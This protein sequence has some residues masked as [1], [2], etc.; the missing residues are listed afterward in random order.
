MKKLF[1]RLFAFLVALTLLVGAAATEGTTDPETQE[2]PDF[3]GAFY[4]PEGYYNSAG[5]YVAAGY[6]FP[7]GT[8]ISKE[9]A[10]MAK[11]KGFALVSLGK[12][13]L[14]AETAGVALTSVVMFALGELQ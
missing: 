12:R 4:N 2:P 1:L 14:R 10:E 8:F 13:I 9:E 5:E 6:Y 7:D 11:A 3:T